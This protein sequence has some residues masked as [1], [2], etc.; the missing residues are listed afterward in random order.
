VHEQFFTDTT[1]YADIVL[2]ATTFFEHKDLQKGYGHY[3]VQVSNQAI[4]PLG[5]CR[6]N[7][8]LFRALAQRMG[9]E[10]ECV[11]ETD[12]EMIDL[13][14]ASKDPWLEGLT[15]RRLEQG[16]LRLNFGDRAS[17]VKDKTAE[18]RPDAGVGARATQPFLPFAHGNFRTA[19]GKAELYSEALKAQGLDPVA[20]FNPPSESRHGAKR[21]QFPL[22]LLARKHDNFLNSTFSNLPSV[23]AMEETGLLEICTKDARARGICDGDPV[24]VFNHRGEIRLQARVDGKVQPGVV[25]ARLNCPKTT[26]GFQSINALTSEKLADMGNSATFYS[27]LVEVERIQAE[28]MKQVQGRRGVI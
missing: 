3:Y 10:E 14:L 2:P 27:V 13:A 9:F 7:V 19:S 26:S 16:A 20:E 28:T 6:S 18:A 22:E 24:R 23:G 25:S 17:G 4:E 12:D 15:R 21:K 8:D 1:D 11:R 5:E